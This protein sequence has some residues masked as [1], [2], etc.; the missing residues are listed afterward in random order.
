[1]PSPLKSPTATETGPLSTGKSVGA[2][3]VPSPLP[4]KIETVYDAALVTARSCFSSP[5]KSPTATEVGARPATKV[6]GGVKL[7][8]LHV[9]GV[10]TASVK[11]LVAVAAPLLKAV[12][13]TVYVPA[14]CASVTRT[15]PVAGSPS[16]LPLKLVEVETVILVVLVGA[17]SGVTVVSVLSGI[18]V[19]G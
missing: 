12:T 19:A 17:A 7:T 8:G 14:G 3:N 1:M 4:S 18:D 2:L 9:A 13:E 6:A 11:V 10:V 16:S 5:L 15:T